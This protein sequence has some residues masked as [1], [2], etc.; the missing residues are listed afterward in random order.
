M[1]DI[2]EDVNQGNSCKYFSVDEFQNSIENSKEIFSCLSLNIRSLKKNCYNL[3]NF[4]ENISTDQFHFSIIGLQELWGGGNVSLVGYQPIISNERVERRGGGVGFF[5]RNNT[6]F[7]KIEELSIFVEGVFESICIKAFCGKDKFRIVANF[8]RPPNCSIS[9]FNKKMEEFFKLLENNQMYKN[10]VEIIFLG[11]FNCNLLN[12]VTHKDTNDFLSLCLSNSFLP[13]ITLPSRVTELSSTLID[14]IWTNSKQSNFLSGL[15][16]E[17]ISDHLPIFYLQ[18][19]KN[20]IGLEK[21]EKIR[22]FSEKNREKFREELLLHNWNNL[23]TTD[24]PKFAFE[25]FANTINEKF[26]ICFPFMEVKRNRRKFPE[27]PWMNLELLEIRKIK[28]KAFKDRV[29]EANDENKQR[30]K[31]SSNTYNKELRKAKKSY[32]DRKFEEYVSN[33]KKTWG[34][35]NEVIRKNK[36]KHSMPSLFFDET[37][38]YETPLDI[39]NGFNDFFVNIGSKLAESIPNTEKSYVDYLNEPVRQ[40][41]VFANITHDIIYDALKKLQPKKSAGLDGISMALVKEIMPCIINQIAYLFNLSFKTGYIPDE[42]KCAKIVPIYKSGEMNKFDNYRPIS[43]L[44]AFSKLLEKI[45]AIQIIKFLEKYEILYSLQFGFRP[46]HNTTQPVLQ[47]LNKV[48][49]NLNKP[50]SEYTLSVFIDLKKAFD[51]VNIPILLD[52]LKRYGFRNKAHDW[53]TSYLTNRSQYVNVWND[54]S[55]KKTITHGVPQGSV[56]GPIL[57]LL[58]IND[59]H[60]ATLFYTLLFADDTS[61]LMS[62]ENLNELTRAANIELEKAYCWFKANKLSLNV[63]KT[64]YIVFRNPKMSF[65]NDITIKIGNEV[66]ERVGHN[67]PIK[68]FKFVGIM[69]DEF[70][71]WT[72]HINHLAHKVASSLYAMRQVKNILPIK[73][74]KL[75]YESMIRPHLDYGVIAWGQSEHARRLD[76]LQKQAV[77]LITNA[78]Y[79]SHSEPLFGNKKIL[80]LS[81]IYSVGVNEFASKYQ[82]DKIPKSCKNLLCPLGN[83][84]TKNFRPPLPKNKHLQSFPSVKIP[85]IWNK[86]SIADKSITKPSKLKRKLSN[87]HT[88]KYKNFTCNKRQCYPCRKTH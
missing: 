45:A 39:S 37:R 80:K 74:K 2:F 14:N 47:L 44:P 16:L 57:F 65:H 68:S 88:E 35:I 71:S 20:N 22:N 86:L 48:F 54:N 59:L 29:K 62:G 81:E 34:L 30:F 9:A 31:V 70:L 60:N 43:I 15:I 33:S 23:L 73:T 21:K 19:Q 61:F 6:K 85:S 56:L 18:V 75:L 41:F 27:K 66:V 52:K 8:Y 78:N 69:I 38:S 5:V 58:Y 55:S 25:Y 10:A 40:N 82:N 13:L 12:H 3:Q 17:H 67:C 42:Y 51:T 24:N 49:E 64:K 87:L 26:E 11:D 28:D 1:V 77:R 7:Q 46:K 32:Y 63:S 76:K 72:F 53:F 84:R 4:I 50:I 36:F 79:N 83:D